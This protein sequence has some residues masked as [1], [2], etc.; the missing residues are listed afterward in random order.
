MFAALTTGSNF[1]SNWRY[2]SHLPEMGFLSLSH[3]V[4]LIDTHEALKT[5]LKCGSYS[6]S[7]YAACILTFPAELELVSLVLL[8]WKSFL[9][10][11]IRPWSPQPHNP[12]TPP[13]PPHTHTPPSKIV[14]ARD[15][16]L[17]CPCRCKYTPLLSHTNSSLSDIAWAHVGVLIIHKQVACV[18]P[19]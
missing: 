11:I 15:Y 17:I 12:T 16:P 5:N 2:H 19:A 18:Y 6:S 14:W 8:L 7:Q 13:P 1:T 10:V 4:I 3:S 9:F